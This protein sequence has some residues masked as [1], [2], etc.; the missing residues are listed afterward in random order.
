[1]VLGAILISLLSVFTLSLFPGVTG[2]LLWFQVGLK[3]R[4]YKYDYLETIDPNE[5]RN[6]IKIPW[7]TLL[8]TE[9]EQIGPRSLKG[10]FFPW[11]D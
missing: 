9:K 1:M 5:P 4:M 8:A 3:L 10:M 2:L 6:K 7:D 11:K